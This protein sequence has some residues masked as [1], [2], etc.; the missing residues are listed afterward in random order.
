MSDSA[1]THACA[2][3]K[4][5]QNYKKGSK[6]RPS[7]GRPAKRLTVLN[8]TSKQT[9]YRSFVKTTGRQRHE[10]HS[11]RWRTVEVDGVGSGIYEQ[12]HMQDCDDLTWIDLHYQP[13]IILIMLP[14][15]NHHKYLVYVGYYNKSRLTR[16]GSACDAVTFQSPVINGCHSE[17]VKWSGS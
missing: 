3:H 1:V 9:V 11:R 13:F 4:R 7:K 15:L 6:E 17:R 2:T 8:K 16:R 12:K 10:W 5:R 14:W